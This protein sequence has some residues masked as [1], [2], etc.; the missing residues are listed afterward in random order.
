MAKQKFYA[1]RKGREI[2]IYT[3]WVEA[4]KRVKSYPSAD[5]KSFATMSDARA[6]LSGY[7]HYIDSGTAE[8]VNREVQKE[9]ACLN[10]DEV[11]AFVDGSFDDGKGEGSRYSFGLVIIST[12]GE[13]KFS[14]AFDDEEYLGSRNVAGEVQGAKEAILWAILHGKS[15]IK[16]YYDY[17][18]I[19]KWALK[20]W[21]ANLKLT[22]EYRDFCEDAMKQIRVSFRHAKSHTGI[23]YNE[24]ADEL[25]KAALKE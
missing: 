15:H 2:G 20:K 7:D 21:K 3:S 6:Y 4:E 23:Y 12:D 5:Y 25:A 16:L 24:M 11:I 10:E 18:G 8:D 22:R 14:H 13:F 1:V 17:E 19:E 9:I